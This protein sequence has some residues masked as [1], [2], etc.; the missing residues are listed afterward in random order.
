MVTQ[1][2][3]HRPLA[4]CA[5]RSV[6]LERPKPKWQRRL[7]CLLRSR[8]CVLLRLPESA[9]VVFLDL[10][11]K[12]GICI[13]FVVDHSLH[14]EALLIA[15][16]DNHRLKIETGGTGVDAQI[17]KLVAWVEETGLRITRDPGIESQ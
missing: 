7:R 3:Q 10:C 9:V 2:L 11:V 8:T 16:L 14:E 5:R 15:L 1:S 4:V 6:V 13:E 12:L 17:S